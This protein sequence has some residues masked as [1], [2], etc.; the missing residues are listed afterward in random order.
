MVQK[1]AYE[2]TQSPGIKKR[3]SDNK[4]ME[5]IYKDAQIKSVCQSDAEFLNLLMNC[6]S[7]LERLNEVP[8]VQQDWID[9]INEWSH[10]DDEEDYIVYAGNTPIGWLGVN[11]L[12]GEDKEAYLKMAVFLPDYQG[13]G[14]GSFTIR[15]L[16][17]RLKHRGFEKIVLYT[18]GDNY[19]AQRC[20]QKC[21]FQIVESL[22]ETMSNGMA[23][24][25][26][27]MEACLL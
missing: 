13:H 10:D 9:A 7:V 18:D 1:E 15:E 12:L 23:V 27:K 2:D 6:P 8:T 25:R 17:S 20:Y 19:K 22:V 5:H 26:I 11:G 16:M 21:G 14:Y 4:Y 24:T 3:I